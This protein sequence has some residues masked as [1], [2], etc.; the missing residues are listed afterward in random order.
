[1]E[2]SSC[3]SDPVAAQIEIG[4]IL[5][6]RWTARMSPMVPADLLGEPSGRLFIIVKPTMDYTV[7]GKFVRT[8]MDVAYRYMF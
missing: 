6:E 4:S 2:S 3:R 8:E 5:N 7:S 1:M